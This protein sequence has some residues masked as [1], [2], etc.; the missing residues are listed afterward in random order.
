MRRS[1]Y[2]SLGLACVVAA[3]MTA[4]PFVLAQ[5]GAQLTP[6]QR[7][8]EQQRQRLSS[9]DIEQRRD[10]L[11]RLGS[12]KR[13]DASRVAATALNDVAVPVRIAAMH[14][15]VFLP[16]AEASG[17]LVPLLQDKNEFVRREA[18]YA[19]GETRSRGAVA[20][21]SE[22]LLGDKEAAV[23]A[24][25][26]VALGEIGDETGVNALAQALSGSGAT[27]K[28]K[29]KQEGE[30]VMRSAARAL[31]QIRSRAGLPALIATLGDERMP[32]DVR[33]EA[34][35]ALGLVGDPSAAPSLHAA[36]DSSDP[37]LSQA[38]RQALRRLAANGK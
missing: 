17:L 32:L 27:H 38:A 14:A 3:E 20:R 21:L 37:Y 7:E 15:S 18:A 11:M 13:P 22:V 33:R 29:P 28:K 19:L 9:G 26:A 10:A 12:M 34:A 4:A 23:R 24:A 1:I 5:T 6:I 30:F 8:I 36:V 35:T 25:A 2:V 31:G 16:S